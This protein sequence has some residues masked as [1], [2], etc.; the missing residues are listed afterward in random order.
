MKRRDR[1]AH[2]A[3]VVHEN[4][5]RRAVNL[6]TGEEEIEVLDA[7]ELAIERL[8]KASRPATAAISR[9]T[10]RSRQTHGASFRRN[11]GS[12]ARN[13]TCTCV[14]G[15]RPTPRNPQ[16]RR[17]VRAQ[18]RFSGAACVIGQVDLEKRRGV[19]LPSGPPRA[20][21]LV[22]ARRLLASGRTSA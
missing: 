19:W 7:G 12:A 2:P 21:A 5:V 6:E 8:F 15:G 16:P 3:V 17:P 10:R 11:G 9:G 1:G 18:R 22:P 4:V 20:Q 13:F 14:T